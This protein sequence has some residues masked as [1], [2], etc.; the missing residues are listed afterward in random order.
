MR[1]AAPPLLPILRS[2]M[3]GALLSL[4]LLQPDRGWSLDET[5]A[6]LDAPVSSVHRELSRA[7]DAGLLW[8]DDAQRPHRYRAATES[9]AYEP[10]RQ[11]LELTFGVPEQM[12]AELAAVPGVRAA[13]IHGS[14]AAG[15]IRPDSDIDV[16]V[17]T[18]GDRRDAQRA[19]RRAARRAGREVD[20]TV[21]SID[22]YRDLE[23]IDNPFLLSVLRQP[24]IDLIGD[25]AHIDLA[26]G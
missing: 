15:R 2:E 4:L 13:A 23:R 19:A 1:T 17:V 14:W 22:D 9:P 18:A 25:V 20:A 11:L 26:G 10:M 8:R 16:L 24:R 3:Q 6:L 7:V 21:L 5:T 12:R